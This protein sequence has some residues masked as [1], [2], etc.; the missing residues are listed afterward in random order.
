MV[1]PP[2]RGEPLRLAP[3]P[4]YQ[5]EA[6]VASGRLLVA[7]VTGAP[8]DML[9]ELR[10]EVHA[11]AADAV[12]LSLPLTSPETA[13]A[14]DAAPGETNFEIARAL[15]QVDSL[16]WSPTGDRLAF[17]GAHQG[18]SSDLY[19]YDVAADAITQLS[20]GPSQAIKPAW[21]PDGAYIVHLGVSTLGSGA[22]YGVEGMWAA[23]SGG[24]EIVTL[25]LPDDSRDEV[26]LG[27]HG[28]HTLLTHSFN[29]SCGNNHLR[30]VDV[31]TGESRTLWRA[32]FDTATFDPTSG[33][34]L[35]SL[36]GRSESC[37]F[38]T[39][40][41]L[42]LTHP[43]AQDSFVAHETPVES[44]RDLGWSAPL[45]S[46][47]A[48]AESVLTITTTGEVHPLPSPIVTIP[49]ISPDG[50]WAAWASEDGLWVGRVG[51]EAPQVYGDAAVLPR[52]TPGRSLL[53]FG[54][55]GLYHA[56]P[57]DFAPTL[58]VPGAQARDAALLEV[59]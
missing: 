21:S 44:A 48:A 8:G 39:R 47:V 33:H 43:R 55:D 40:P 50:V 2:D 53:F 20:S 46:F 42:L 19:L 52:W 12:L 4:I 15:T 7:F 25:D 30:A 41:G 14:P 26:W 23:R 18:S 51:E 13:I 29:P 49:A 34:V 32:D 1:L 58:I 6:S 9:S 57:P 16:A 3:A 35:F 36:G 54:A 31:A 37:A 24:E 22:G 56:P 5:W 59:P 28:D 38:V 17:M 27:W 11:P 10:L 45:D